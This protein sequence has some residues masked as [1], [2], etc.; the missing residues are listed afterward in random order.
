MLG[1]RLKSELKRS[2]MLSAAAVLAGRCNSSLLQEYGF[3]TSEKSLTRLVK[4]YNECSGVRYVEYKNSLPWTS[5]GFSLATGLVSSRINFFDNDHY[6][7]MDLAEF[8]SVMSLNVGAEIKITSPRLSQRTNFILGAYYQKTDYYGFYSDNRG[9]S[10]NSN[11]DI[12]INTTLLRM[13]VGFGFKV[14]PGNWLLNPSLGININQYLEVDYVRIEQRVYSNQ[15]GIT[16]ISESYKNEL[17][18]ELA[19]N[20][21]IWV[22]VGIHKNISKNLDIGMELRLENNA[23]SFYSISSNLNN[24]QLIFS[25]NYNK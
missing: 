24:F 3:S 18:N 8:K 16:V 25:L 12:Y 5:V 13:P 17:R 15:N 20:I 7:F 2:N 4:A 22:G 1:E 14:R 6:R 11:S 9:T 19:T 10:S 23:A 21:G